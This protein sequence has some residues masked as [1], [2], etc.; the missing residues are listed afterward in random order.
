MYK[1]YRYE[2]L[3]LLGE[4]FYIDG[5]SSLS[6]LQKYFLGYHHQIGFYLWELCS[7]EQKIS[8][9]ALIEENILEKSLEYVRISWFFDRH[10]PLDW[11]NYLSKTQLF[12][13]RQYESY[14]LVKKKYQAIERA[15]YYQDKK[16]LNLQNE[17]YTQ[18][19]HLLYLADIFYC[20]LPAMYFLKD[21]VIYWYRY[22]WKKVLDSV[23]RNFSIESFVEFFQILLDKGC[24]DIHRLPQISV[25]QCLLY[26]F[27]QYH[28]ILEQKNY[29]QIN[30]QEETIKILKYPKEITWRTEE[31]QKELHSWKAIRQ[32]SAPFL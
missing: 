15:L 1:K 24:L 17:L 30:H 10:S 21:E 13:G 18:N 7:K 22:W 16:I 2:V 8:L 29:I 9:C 11:L 32:I 14:G 31:I 4:Q 27:S 6:Q 25:R 20:V 12:L 23:E 3:W 19:Q 26:F 28:L 5:K